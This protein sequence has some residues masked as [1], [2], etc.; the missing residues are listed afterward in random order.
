MFHNTILCLYKETQIIHKLLL[1]HSHFKNSQQQQYKFRSKQTLRHI[2]YS[3]ETRHRPEVSTTDGSST[4]AVVRKPLP[5]LPHGGARLQFVNTRTVRRHQNNG[6]SA[7]YWSSD[8]GEIINAGTPALNK[9]GRIHGFAWSCAIFF[10]SI[11]IVSSEGYCWSFANKYF[12]LSLAMRSWTLYYH[13]YDMKQ[14]KQAN[15]RLM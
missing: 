10:Y 14:D 11:N 1:K 2:S 6:A 9:G 15:P 5:T 7:D 13:R 12:V 4:A 3:Y 8:S